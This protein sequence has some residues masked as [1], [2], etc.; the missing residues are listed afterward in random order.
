MSEAALGRGLTVDTERT[1]P[2]AAAAPLSPSA[3]ALRFNALPW[4]RHAGISRL[5]GELAGADGV[6]TK[7]L[8]GK[9]SPTIVPWRAFSHGDLAGMTVAGTT[10]EQGA[11]ESFLLYMARRLAMDLGEL[12]SLDLLSA[13]RMTKLY[14]EPEYFERH[15]SR[16]VYPE[17][18]PRGHPAAQHVHSRRLCQHALEMGAP[19]WCE[20]DRAG[21]LSPADGAQLTLRTA[22]VVPFNTDHSLHGPEA[23]D[24]PQMRAAR[25]TPRAHVLVLYSAR[26]VPQQEDLLARLRAFSRA[27]ATTDSMLR[28]L[29]TIAE[30]PA[31]AEACPAHEATHARSVH[32]RLGLAPSASLPSN[33]H[34]LD[35]PQGAEGAFGA[36][37]R[38]SRMQSYASLKDLDRATPEEAPRA[39][40][41]G[42]ATSTFAQRRMRQIL[43]RSEL[44]AF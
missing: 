34:L 2:P 5:A 27:V 11:T 44:P 23:A 19:L 7:R 14:I 10:A 20:L 37:R 1:S 17:G 9:A 13:L 41:L 43:E 31:A 15:G 32:D 16:I 33:M 39:P 26:K 8:R 42:G 36:L 40:K 29:S 18:D 38:R 21:D 28:L 3:A 25:L 12:W 6:R 35:D 22:V 30:P 24:S 4:P